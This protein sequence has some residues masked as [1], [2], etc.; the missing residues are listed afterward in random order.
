M[1]NENEIRNLNEGEFEKVSGGSD[2]D[3][4]LK[5]IV[6]EISRNVDNDLSETKYKCTKCGIRFPVRSSNPLR[7]RHPLRCSKCGGY[8]IPCGTDEYDRGDK[9]EK[10]KQ[11]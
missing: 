3:T 2:K 4:E 8:C 10:R 6:D 9:H 7:L 1:G 5:K 11:S